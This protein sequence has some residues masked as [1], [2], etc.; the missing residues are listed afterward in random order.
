M[1]GACNLENFE[2][3]LLEIEFG[4]NFGKE[5]NS[6]SNGISIRLQNVNSLAVY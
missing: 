5:H 1:P 6:L 4:I 2:I 3:R